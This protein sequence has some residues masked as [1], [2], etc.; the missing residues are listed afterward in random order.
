MAPT[1]RFHE[2]LQDTLRG[3]VLASLPFYDQKNVI[4]LLDRLPEMPE[5]DL[6]GWDPVLM[7]VLSACIIHKRF[8][9]GKS[10]PNDRS[11]SSLIQTNGEPAD[12]VPDRSELP[13]ERNQFN[14]SSDAQD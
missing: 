2:M 5:T 4:A 9:L 1:E 3:P 12:S 13:F 7:S 10:V 8:G 14:G 11:Y 6:I